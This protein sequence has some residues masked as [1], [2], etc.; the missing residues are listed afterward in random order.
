MFNSDEYKRYSRHFSLHGFG[1]EGQEKLK[2][3]SVL[4]V[5]CGGLAA[6]A[7]TYL[8]ASGIGEIGVIDDDIVDNSNLQRQV[9]F[10]TDD[11]GKKK[12]EIAQKRINNLNPNVKVEIHD[13]RLNETNAI[14]I[15][16]KFDVVIDC[17]DNFHAK[18]LIND[19]C[20]EQ[21]KPFVYGSVFQ[22]EGQLSFFDGKNSPCFRCLFASPPAQ[23]AFGNCAEEGIL[24]VLPGV[25]GT[26]QALEAIKYLTKI[27]DNLL[28]KLFFFNT[29]AMQ[30]TSLQ[31]GKSNDCPICVYNGRFHNL[32]RPELKGCELYSTNS[33][34][35][36]ELKPIINDVTLIDVREEYEHKI[37]NI[38]GRLI[39]LD[40]LK[41]S[42][43]SINTENTI[44]VYCK[45]GN[46]SK[47]AVQILNDSGF[48]AVCSL[49]GGI[50]A[51]INQIDN[52]L[53]QY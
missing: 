31:F 7:I 16:E 12:V 28:G 21:N 42:L 50:L 41:S 48:K 20:F 14:K 23:G 9:L 33:I 26:L 53:I 43:K 49:E 6:S 25:I 17:T 52:M 18:Y 1:I 19:A 24:G 3:S 35:P 40:Q 8:A 39:P 13:A 15:I 36:R 44:V 45:S 22:F 51:W 11:I 37:C 2:N 38:G 4:C 47:K 32:V 29:L 30:A 27:G 34:S 46:R 5:G 10:D